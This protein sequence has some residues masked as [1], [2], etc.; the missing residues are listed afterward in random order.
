VNEP[1]TE[2]SVNKYGQRRNVI[3]SESPQ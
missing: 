2:P 1:K 3:D